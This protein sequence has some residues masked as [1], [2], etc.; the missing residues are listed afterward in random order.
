VRLAFIGDGEVDLLLLLIPVSLL[1]LHWLASLSYDS[2]LGHP[3][4]VS[5][6]K[7]KIGVA[8]G[9]SWHIFFPANTYGVEIGHSDVL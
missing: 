8:T 7:V 3:I 4:Q 9:Q 6:Y 2:P 1:F 5:F